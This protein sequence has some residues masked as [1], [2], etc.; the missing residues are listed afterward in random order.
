MAKNDERPE[1]CLWNYIFE[2]CSCQYIKTERAYS[3]F[4]TLFGY[5]YQ[6][7]QLNEHDAK[8]KLA[9]KLSHKNNILDWYKNKFNA[10]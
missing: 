6:E 5:D 3:A 8:I 7:Y 2:N 1:I 9:D 10:F 4:I